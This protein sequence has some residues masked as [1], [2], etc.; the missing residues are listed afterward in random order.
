M[1]VILT[2]VMN[3]WWTTTQHR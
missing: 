1:T 2:N 3:C